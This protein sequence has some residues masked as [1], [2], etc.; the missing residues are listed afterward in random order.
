MN[1]I[2]DRLQYKLLTAFLLLSLVPL[3]IF[4]FVSMTRTTDSMEQQ[5]FNQLKSVRGI[6]QAQINSYFS[7]RKGDMGVLNDLVDTF[8]SDT[9]HGLDAIQH[10]KHEQ[11]NAYFAMTKANMNL[12]KINN[13]VQNALKNFSDS[14]SGSS[15]IDTASWRSLSNRYG[16]TFEDIVKRYGW[17]DFFLINSNGDIVYTDAKESDLGQNLKTDLK[18]SALGNVFTKAQ[19]SDELIISD[20]APYAPSNGEPAGFMIVSVTDNFG[21]NAGYIAM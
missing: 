19:N 15:S 18:E 9:I 5:A 1:L 13:T 14:F 10:L 7:E 2:L 17:Y 16:P 6:K 8:M 12:L 21:F 4:A 11:L 20:F 3:L